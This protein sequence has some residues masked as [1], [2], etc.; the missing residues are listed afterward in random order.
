MATPPTTMLCLLFCPLP[1]RAFVGYFFF[2]FLLLSLRALFVCLLVVWLLLRLYSFEFE[3]TQFSCI[4]FCSCIVLGN[5]PCTLSL[6]LF[7][8]VNWISVCWLHFVVDAGD[9]VAH[10][11][12]LYAFVHGGDLCIRNTSIGSYLAIRSQHGNTFRRMRSEGVAPYRTTHLKRCSEC[13][14]NKGMRPKRFT[15]KKSY[16]SE[17]RDDA[18]SHQIQY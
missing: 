2:L 8:I 3:S 16:W 6:L 7:S 18:I 14:E 1:Y 11:I 17:D 13:A 12:G 9:V 15:A 4:T 10:A 5:N